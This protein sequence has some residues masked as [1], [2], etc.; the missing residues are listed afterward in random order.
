MYITSVLS[1]LGAWEI[2]QRDF[3][4]EYR[5]LFDVIKGASS[6]RSFPP[7]GKN[8]ALGYNSITT[9]NIERDLNSGFA[10]FEWILKDRIRLGDKKRISLMKAI[11]NGIGIEYG[12]AKFA[13]IESHVFVKIPLFIRS[14][15]IKIGLV[16]ALMEEAT[17]KFPQGMGN[18]EFVADRISQIGEIL[19]KY[20]FAIIG[21]SNRS[22]PLNIMELTSALDMYLIQ[23]VGYS[24][25]EMRLQTERKNFDFKVEL[26]SKSDKIAKELC[27]IA[28]LHDGGLLLVG[29]DNSGNLKGILKS[30]LDTVQQ[31]VSQIAHNNVQPKPNITFNVFE[32]PGDSTRCILI[33]HI[34]EI[35]RKPCIANERV[36]IRSGNIAIAAK[37]EEIRKLV[38][39]L[40]ERA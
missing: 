28:N 37:P 25:V 31:Q 40:P 18:F 19:P 27:A 8:N 20:P 30:T 34:S 21:I 17:D 33:I 14:N 10:K 16:L 13:F 1:H 35:N 9:G 11:K 23:M 3:P 6:T 29:V 7:K 4:N 39:V 5:E 36:Y 2:F 24:L 22:G 12:F 15:K 32:M 26:P 38:S